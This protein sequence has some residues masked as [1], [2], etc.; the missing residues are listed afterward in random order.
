M[1]MYFVRSG[2][3]SWLTGA[4]QQDSP[5]FSPGL[6]YVCEE[7]VYFFSAHLGS[8]LVLLLSPAIQKHT[9]SP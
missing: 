5:V 1:L 8:L 3:A 7:L 4:W 9:D 6:G 2:A